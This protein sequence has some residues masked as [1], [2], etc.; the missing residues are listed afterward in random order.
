MTSDFPAPQCSLPQPFET[1][2]EAGTPAGTCK[3]KETLGERKHEGANA[4]RR[5]T[6]IYGSF[7]IDDSEFAIPVSAVQEVVNEPEVVSPVPLSPPYMLG[8]FNLRGKIIPVVDLRILLKFPKTEDPQQRKVAIIEHGETCIGLACDRT[9]EVLHGQDAARVDLRSNND[10]VKDVVV[11]GV[12]KFDQGDRLVQILDP[13]ELLKLE[14]VPNAENNTDKT[15]ATTATGRR[16]TCI[17]F[18]TGHTTCAIDLRY[19]KEVKEM[20]NVD[21]VV[22]T[23]GCI[24]GTTNLRGVITPV[25]DFRKFMGDDEAFIIGQTNPKGRKLL[26]IE[27]SEGPV[28]LMVF[29][30]DS[31][32]TYYEGSILDFA[33]LALPR[34]DFVKGCLIDESEK[35]VMMLDHEK[36]LGEPE[37][38]SVA[39]SCQEIYPSKGD[40]AAEEKHTGCSTRRTFIQFSFERKFALETSQVSEVINCPNE[41]LEPPFSL[42]FVEGIFNLRN[43]LITIFNPRK[44]Y[45]LSSIPSDDQKVLIFKNGEQK[46]GLL[47]D[48][49]DEIIMMTKGG[50]TELSLMDQQGTTQKLA[51]DIVGCLHHELPNGNVSSVMVLDV[52]ALVERCRKTAGIRCETEAVVPSL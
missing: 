30:I 22:F 46:Y 19:V 26:V 7:L 12:L 16:L 36:L 2:Q 15:V 13:F 34:G 31:I 43:E 48:S 4:Q 41:L 8:L 3:N 42:S 35:I 39:K 6:E 32:L 38:V 51:E 23:H 28:G 27:T 9:G 17:A 14:K 52:D 1:P 24:I 11:A 49:V 50:L 29:S 45:R 21:Q 47:V 10:S 33:K 40:A 18:Q 25:V 37:F 20:G 5:R 44:L